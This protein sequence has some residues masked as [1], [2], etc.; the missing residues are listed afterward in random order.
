M[1]LPSGRKLSARIRHGLAFILSAIV[2]TLVVAVFNLFQFGVADSWADLRSS[3]WRTLETGV[4]EPLATM[5]AIG[6][7]GFGPLAIAYM[8]RESL[9]IRSRRRCAG[10]VLVV[11]VA[12]GMV[13]SSAI[14]G[15]L[16]SHNVLDQET[17]PEQRVAAVA[18][19]A[20]S[21]MDVLQEPGPGESIAYLAGAH[22]HVT[23]DTGSSF[24]SRIA[25][26]LRNERAQT[27]FNRIISEKCERVIVRA[28]NYVVCVS[29][30]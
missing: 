15:V 18:I 9:R 16:M 13:T 10:C 24:H 20:A 11:V 25:N 3:W 19:S 22:F 14:F 6:L 8:V 5:A 4:S 17:L 27:V 1:R 12:M 21:V 7:L 2:P 30:Q 26:P 28:E 29:E 23:D